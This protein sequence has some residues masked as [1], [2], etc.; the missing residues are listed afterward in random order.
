MIG[1]TRITIYRCNGMT[2][3]LLAVSSSVAIYKS[4]TLARLLR[5]EGWGVTCIMTEHATKFVA[6]VMFASLSGH[7]VMTDENYLVDHRISHISLAREC[8]VM[9]IAP[10]TANLIGKIANGLA[11]DL[12]STTALV[13]NRPMFVAP[14]MNTVMWESPA[15]QRNVKQLQQDGRHIIEPISD[16]LACGEQGKGKMQEPE[17]ILRIIKESLV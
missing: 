14:A 12:V 7:E 6:P 13:C 8:D 3:V 4:L 9:L 10:A 11:D 5:K 2:N 1:L 17:E 15:V 16:V